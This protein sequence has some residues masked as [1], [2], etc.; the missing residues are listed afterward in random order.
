M[1]KIVVIA[2]IA[3]ACNVSAARCQP[4]E[5]PPSGP[6]RQERQ[7]GNT[8]DK[9]LDPTKWMEQAIERILNP[10]EETDHPVTGPP[11]Q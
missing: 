11:E 2:A 4:G 7:I 10:P 9:P 3:A 1:L 8:P 6:I 5:P